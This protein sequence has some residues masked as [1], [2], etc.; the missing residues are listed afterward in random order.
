M[1]GAQGAVELARTLR[2][3]AGLKTR[4]PLA[5]V[6]IA[7]PEKGMAFQDEL[8][9]LIADEI[10]VKK[11][12]VIDDDSTLVERRVKPL[13]PRIGKRLGFAIP[14]VMAAARSGDVSY[15]G[16]GSVTLAGVTLAPDE[17]EIQAEARP[18]TAVASHDGLVVVL[19]TRIDADLAA[20]GDARE[21][22]RAIQEL[23]KG[24]NL[25]LD[26]TAELWLGPLSDA[27]DR[28]VATIAADTRVERQ[29]GPAP[30]NG[31]ER[32]A[33]ELSGGPVEVALRRRPSDG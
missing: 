20:E 16:D 23:R 18:G 24:A 8:L 26:E 7:L 22:Q 9:E 15:G 32:A 10:N 28:H 14:A 30:A 27:V 19:D 3:S 12:T 25:D 5:E 33:V 11:V 17:V 6:W 31:T 13:L 29:D 4:Q 21:L 1:A 2:G